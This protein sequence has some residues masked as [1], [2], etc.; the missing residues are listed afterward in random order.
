MVSAWREQVG[1]HRPLILDSGQDSMP[2]FGL[3]NDDSIIQSDGWPASNRAFLVELRNPRP[4]T[5]SHAYVMNGN[6]VAGNVDI[7]IYGYASGTGFT[8]E[9]LAS[10]GSTADAGTNQVQ[11]IEF[12]TKPQIPAGPIVLAIAV[13]NTGAQIGKRNNLFSLAIVEGLLG[14]AQEDSAFPLPATLTSPAQP[15]GGFGDIPLFGVTERL[16]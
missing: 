3:R 1:R 13:Q 12:G 8:L 14:I 2:S 9:L 6:T 11:F 5:P 4:F 7:G 10:T 15:T 16:F